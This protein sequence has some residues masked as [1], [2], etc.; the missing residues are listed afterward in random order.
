MKTLRITVA[1]EVHRLVSINS[2]LADNGAEKTQ[3]GWF[4]YFSPNGKRMLL[5]PHVYAASHTELNSLR[6][7]WRESPLMTGSKYYYLPDEKTGDV[8]HW[9]ILKNV[10]MPEYQGEPLTR[11]LRSQ[12]GLRLY[13]ATFDTKDNASKLGKRLEAIA[14]K[15]LKDILVWTRQMSLRPGYPVGALAL[16]DDGNR[17]RVVSGGLDSFGYSGHSREICIVSAKDAKR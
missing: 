12:D 5:A 1:D 4:T 9:D 14:R 2:Q 10:P 13:Q 11:V 8:I 3:E 6:L 16:V 15:E 7:G 17:F